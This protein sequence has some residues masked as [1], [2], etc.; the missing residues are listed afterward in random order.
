MCPTAPLCQY[1]TPRCLA[2]GS[3][4]KLL[5]FGYWPVSLC[6]SHALLVEQASR[7]GLGPACLALRM[8]RDCTLDDLG[9]NFTVEAISLDIGVTRSEIGAEAI[10]LRHIVGTYFPDYS[11]VEVGEL[12][13]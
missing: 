11:P 9:E 13:A 3:A 6:S 8:L 7:M 2:V 12:Q 1:T 5:Q 10:K 4:T